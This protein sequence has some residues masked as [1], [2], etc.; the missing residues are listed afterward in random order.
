M[1]LEYFY[2]GIG[3]VRCSKQTF[4]FSAIV[5]EK[6]SRLCILPNYSFPNDGDIL[7]QLHLSLIHDSKLQMTRWKDLIG[8]T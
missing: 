1:Q 8:A 4:W 6:I 2:F 3:L 5:A 7:V